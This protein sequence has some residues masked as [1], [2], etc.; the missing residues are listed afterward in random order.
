MIRSGNIL[1]T[2]GM[3]VRYSLK[4]QV[5]PAITLT[6]SQLNP[7]PAVSVKTAVSAVWQT[8]SK[9]NVRLSCLPVMP[10]L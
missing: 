1:A 6:I 5:C 10:T 4:N 8:P 7:N 2:E 9:N 3:T